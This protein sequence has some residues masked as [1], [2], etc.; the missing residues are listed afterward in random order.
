MAISDDEKYLLN[1]RMGSV[2]NKVQLGTL[3]DNAENPTSTLTEGYVYVGNSSNEADEVQLQAGQILVGDSADKA[4]AVDVTGDVTLS[5]AGVTAIAAG[6]IVDADVNA[7]ADIA[8]SKLATTAKLVKMQRMSIGYAA[9]NTATSGVKLNVGTAIPDN[10][11]ITRVF[12]EVLTTFADNGTAGDQDTSTL[13]LG[14]EN[15]DDDVKASVSIADGANAWDA[16]LHEG[17]QDGTAANML[18]L[19]A[20]RQLAVKWTAGSGDSTALT[21][22]SMDVFVEYVEGQ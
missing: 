6:V 9:L 15:Q 20:A 4:A 13:K 3:I 2:A 8:L 22:G 12:Y 18:K 16:G 7:S 10:S 17:I 21:A 14:I 5:D 11:I 19:S 1:N